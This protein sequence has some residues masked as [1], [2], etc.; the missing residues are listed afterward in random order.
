MGARLNS[1]QGRVNKRQRNLFRGSVAV[2]GMWI[3]VFMP[4]YSQSAEQADSGKAADFQR[5][6]RPVLSKNCL[7]CHGP[8]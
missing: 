6:I 8:G 7:S 2:L 4:I 5:E 3:G 1:R